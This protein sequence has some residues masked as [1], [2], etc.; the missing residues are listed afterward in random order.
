MVRE[1]LAFIDSYGLPRD[2][3]YAGITASAWQR[4][5]QGHGLR[6]GDPKNF[7]DATSENIARRV[8]EKLLKCGIDGGAGGGGEVAPKFVYVFLKQPHT[9]R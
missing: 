8:E 5:T 7:W 4:L 6:I 9:R 1:I 3:W 2:S